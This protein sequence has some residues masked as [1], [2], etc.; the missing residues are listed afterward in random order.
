MFYTNILN[1]YSYKLVNDRHKIIRIKENKSNAQLTCTNLNDKCLVPKA[2]IH[3][4][5]AHV[6]SLIDKVFNA[7]K[8]TTTSGRY[9]AMNAT[10]TDRLPCYTSMSIDVLQ[11]RKKSRKGFSFNNLNNKNCAFVF[12]QL[13]A[14][15]VTH[16]NKQGCWQDVVYLHLSY[17]LI[18]L[19]T[20]QLANRTEQNITA[21]Q[22][23][24]LTVMGG[25]TVLKGSVSGGEIQ[26]RF[27]LLD[28]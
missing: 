23:K 19:A 24:Q 16:N 2:R 21:I 15:D 7:M 27:V 17:P 26:G 22:T 1:T 12:L 20:G 6:G 10:L 8:H 4:Q 28:P 25:Q 14:K 13:N 9:T 3:V 11:K 5:L 18:S